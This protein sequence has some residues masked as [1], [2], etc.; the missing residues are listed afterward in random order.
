[1]VFIFYLGT[2]VKVQLLQE[3]RVKFNLLPY[4][5]FVTIFPIFIGTFLRLPKLII[6]I[7][8]EKQWSFDW[9][10]VVAIGFPTLYLAMAPILSLYF[11]PN[12]LFAKSFWMAGDTTL[13]S[14][15]GIVFGYVLLDS[16]KK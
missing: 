12:M 14:I 4:L 9:I 7:R 6:E 11:G 8:Q 13:T 15:A 5:I 2:E 10:K 1:M 3:S 16:L